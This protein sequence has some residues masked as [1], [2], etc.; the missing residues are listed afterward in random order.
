[1]NFENELATGKI[2]RVCGMWMYVAIKRYYFGR[3]ETKIVRATFLT[4]SGPGLSWYLWHISNMILIKCF[5]LLPDRKDIWSEILTKFSLGIDLTGIGGLIGDC[6]S[7]VQLSP[8][9]IVSPSFSPLDLFQIKK[10]R[11]RSARLKSWSLQ[12]SSQNFFCLCLCVCICHCRCHYHGWWSV[13]PVEIK[14]WSDPVELLIFI[15]KK[16][17]QTASIHICICSC[18]EMFR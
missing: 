15:L 5:V 18:N 12:H 6:G 3:K 13:S 11:I 10:T 9:V 17:V 8:V 2:G 4:A 7:C 16:N 1:M 14:S